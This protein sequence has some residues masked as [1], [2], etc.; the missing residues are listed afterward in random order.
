MA[1]I[2]C[3]ASC[4]RRAEH[5]TDRGV[6]IVEVGNSD[7]HLEAAFPEVPFLWLDFRARRPGV[8]ALTADELDAHAAS[9]A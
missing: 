4:V 9:F 7:H 1:W 5:L 2:S 3:G 6:L 8:F